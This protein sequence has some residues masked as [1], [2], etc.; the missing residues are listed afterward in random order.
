MHPFGR[1]HVGCPWHAATQRAVFGSQAS[2]AGQSA[3]RLQTLPWHTS[4]PQV[5]GADGSGWYAQPAGGAGQSGSEVQPWHVPETHSW[6]AP[7][8]AFEL[9]VAQE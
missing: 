7:H 2:P 9:H 1:V 3:S 8:C 5:H 6:N 4:W